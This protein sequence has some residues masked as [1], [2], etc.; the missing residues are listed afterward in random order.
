MEDDLDEDCW[1]AWDDRF[2]AEGSDYVKEEE[3]LDSENEE[4]L[5][6][7]SKE[8]QDVD[9]AGH[10]NV[11]NQLQVEHSQSFQRVGLKRL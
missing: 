8:E 4:L 3:D 5:N 1:D 10:L 6:N 2:E 7:N 9:V 11:L